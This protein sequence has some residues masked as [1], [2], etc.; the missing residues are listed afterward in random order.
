MQ[1]GSPARPI[2]LH[3]REFAAGRWWT[4]PQLESADPVLLDPNMGRFL[5]K[6]RGQPR[7]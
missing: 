4:G 2:A 5:A 3:P 1:A 7:A 6:S